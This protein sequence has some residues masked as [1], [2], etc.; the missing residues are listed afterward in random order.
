MA[1]VVTVRVDGMTCG[2]C[3]ATIE[4]VIGHSKG[5]K[6]IKVSWENGIAMVQY[7][8]TQTS[9]AV[10]CEDIDDMGFP[11][12]LAPKVSSRSTTPTNS[13]T[14]HRGTNEKV[15]NIKIKVEGMTCDSCSASIEDMLG[16][17]NGV[18]KIAVSWQQGF[19]QIRYNPAVISATELCEAIEDMGFDATPPSTTPSRTTSSESLGSAAKNK[20]V[21][22]A[23]EGM[24]CGSC[25]ASIE[26][27][28]GHHDG[29]LE[30]KVSLAEEIAMIHYKPSTTSPNALVDAIDD[31]GFT[32]RLTSA[33]SPS[34]LNAHRSSGGRPS[35]NPNSGSTTP[36]SRRTS[37][38]EVTSI[39]T[40]IRVEG[41][42]CGSCTAS[43]EDMIGNH[44]G[45]STVKV[46]LADELAV[47]RYTPSKTSPNELREAIEDMGFDAFIIPPKSR[48]NDSIVDSSQLL[49]SVSPQR[50]TSTAA[51][52][53]DSAH[54]GVVQ[55]GHRA[56]RVQTVTNDRE[57][58]TQKTYM[59][60]SGMKCASCVALIETKLKRNKGIRD[61]LVGLLAGQA[62][63]EFYPDLLNPDAIV[64][65][66]SGIGFTAAITTRSNDAKLM[67]SYSWK[68]AAQKNTAD[69]KDSDFNATKLK[70]VAM[71]MHGMIEADVDSDE[72]FVEFA[73]DP[74][75]IGPRTIMKN[76]Q[77]EGFIVVLRKAGS[78]DGD[79]SVK[80]QRYWKRTLILSLFFSVPI[81]VFMLW[82]E[83]LMTTF[84][85]VTGLATRHVVEFLL[86]TGAMV[87]VGR[88]FIVS[89]VLALTHGSATM[90]T[91]IMLGT[92]FAYLFSVVAVLYSAAT[93]S[94]HFPVVFFDT[95]P[96]LFSFVAVG[97]YF[98][99][100]A[101]GKTSAALKKLMELQ[102]T[103]ALLMT[104]NED[105]GE[106]LEQTIDTAL[107][108]RGDIL[109][110]LPGGKVPVDGVVVEGDS[111]IDEALIT[112]EAMPVPK[113]KGD[114]VIG[115]TINQNSSLLIRATHVGEDASLAQIVTLMEQAQMTKAPIQRAADRIAMYFV[116]VICFIALAT[117]VVWLAIM[118]SGSFHGHM[119]EGASRTQMAFQ[120]AI[121]VLV[122]AC[123]CALGLATP[124]AVMVG[125]GIGAQNGVLIKGGAA[126]EMLSKCTTIIFD[127]T[128]T[129]TMGQPEVTDVHVTSSSGLE[130]RRLL[131]I[132]G[133]AEKDSE[134]PL[135]RSIVQHA[136]RVLGAKGI[137]TAKNFTANPGKGVECYIDDV[138]VCVGTSLLMADMNI[139]IDKVLDGRKVELECAAKTVV[140]VAYNRQAIGLVAMADTVKPDAKLAVEALKKM[141]VNIVMLTGDNEQTAKAIARQLGIDNV[142]ANVLP[143]H[144]AEH[145][146]QSQAS[147]E[148]VAMVGDGLNDSPAL[149]QADIGI[150]IG[151]GAD[152]AVEAADVVLIQDR[153]IDVLVAIDLSAATVRRVHYNFIW[154]VIYN[155]VGIPIAAGCF[156]PLGIMLKP[157]WASAAMAFSSVS[158]VTSSLLLKLYE[159]PT[160]TST[161]NLRPRAGFFVRLFT[162]VSQ[163][164]Q[165]KRRTRAMKGGSAHLYQQLV[166]DS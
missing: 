52:K 129:L 7:D 149:A 35:S 67:L 95:G 109:K 18:L 9:P 64:H 68:G 2:S 133:A 166:D 8:P 100:Q 91:L 122:I 135:G 102:P 139:D 27:V 4:D 10:I 54:G 16:H 165:K 65:L 126:L 50:P 12:K 96:M 162:A 98:E 1:S 148:V 72:S 39:V 163:S 150:A 146:K 106:L 86:S 25:T 45:V 151:T 59:S 76:L 38:S 79:K 90:D 159:T 136:E 107:V 20:M 164:I 99:H 113:T 19:A 13:A 84:A 49:T 142:V 97:R 137:P 73:F 143:S 71:G 131:E 56:V 130:E 14:T 57:G 138:H 33:P 115:G 144:K 112:G 36:S 104:V 87:F 116:P 61:V 32:A 108:H 62:E 111:H 74:E 124:T 123:P 5:V 30:I 75:K 117:L 119:A 51:P 24:T 125:T 103:E 157:V 101:K 23:I 58:G 78:D 15:K 53:M 46:S 60:I 155:A 41:M 158:V 88:P 92:S 55:K 47:V 66:I 42:T 134:H 37:S 80:E 34:R 160:Y 28:I 147:G 127:K 31:M 153:L 77:A 29:V 120:F 82:K 121:A 3:S 48:K 110:V 118:H 161:G 21:Q 140:I 22:I 156:M 26:D 94:E 105:N 132:V 11:A 40:T 44:D 70:A 63:I 114:S 128:G 83:A 6:D 85:G 17:R 93:K 141:G 154:A 152:V 43:I 89:G 81:M 69:T 145:V